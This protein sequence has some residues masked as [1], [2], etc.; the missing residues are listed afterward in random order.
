MKTKSV[1]QSETTEEVWQEAQKW[2]ESHWINAQ[3][4]RAKFGKNWIWRFLSLFNVVPKHRGDDW[5]TWWMSQFDNY[6]FLPAEVS[7]VI[8]VG[9]G[10][11]TNVRLMQERCKMHHLVL[12]DP[13]IQTYAKFKLTF[14]SD[15]HKKVACALDYHPLEELPYKD[16]NFD[17]AV[18]INVLDHV[19]D[20]NAC[21][22]N[23]Y[24][25]VK[26]GGIVVFGQD[27]SREEDADALLSD[28]GLI[29]HPI[30]LHAEW[31]EPWIQKCEPIIHRI[32]KREE[33]RNDNKHYSTLIF[34]GRL[35][36]SN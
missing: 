25:V 7:N 24:R 29:G 23:L 28:P 12:S 30:K 8:E 9:C 16:A 20:A 1:L 4:E 2:E 15:M 11:Y 18:M 19:R 32:L 17:L 6:S 27:L 21:M 14:V 34:A 33:G 22:E 31:F 10:P 35:K 3:R 26:P 13:L 5:N 36:S